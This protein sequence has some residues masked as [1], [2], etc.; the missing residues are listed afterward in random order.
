MLEPISLAEFEQCRDNKEALVYLANRQRLALHEAPSQSLF[1]V[2]ALFYCEVGPRANRTKEVIEGYNAEQSYIGGAICAERAALTQL[3]KYTD[4]TILEIVITTDS[5]EAI[6]PGILCREYLSTSAEPDT[7]IVLGNNDGSIISTFALHEIHPYPYVYRM[8]RRDQM[9]RAGEAFGLK[10]RQ[11]NTKNNN[12][13]TGWSEKERALYDA[14]L[15][16]VDTSPRILSLHP[17]SFGAAVRFADDS[18]ES[19]G[20]LPALEYGASV[21]PVQLLCRELDKRVRA[22]GPRP[23]ELVQ[24]D[25]YGTAH[26]PFASARTLLNEH[27]NKDL[28]VLYHDEEALERTCLSADL[29]P[30]PPGASFL[31]HDAFLGTKDQGALRLL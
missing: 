20:Y 26:C 13:S 6:S 10:C 8:Y 23:V 1:R 30:P 9:A 11:C 22:D 3:R 18:V 16:A 19:S 17:I 4:P 5:V 24:V 15:K 28:K 12:E 14:A 31:T 21:C 25:Q 27:F 7:T 2:V 29:C